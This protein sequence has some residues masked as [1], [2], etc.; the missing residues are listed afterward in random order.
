[1]ESISN[2]GSRICSFVPSKLKELD[3]I[4]SFKTQS[5]KWQPDNCPRR[6]Y[7][8]YVPQVGFI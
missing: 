2:L 5:K 8:T 7:K 6:L 4:S 3:D 1:M